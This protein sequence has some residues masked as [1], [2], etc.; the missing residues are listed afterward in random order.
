MF[1][2][3]ISI[4]TCCLSYLL[5]GP[6]TAGASLQLVPPFVSLSLAKTDSINVNTQLRNR[7]ITMG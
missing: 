7:L 5:A 1:V 6:V 4:E 2:T 3:K